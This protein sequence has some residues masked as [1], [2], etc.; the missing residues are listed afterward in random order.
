VGEVIATTFV[1][2]AGAWGATIEPRLVYGLDRSN[3][4][5]ML[6]VQFGHAMDGLCWCLGEFEALSATLAT[7]YPVAT[8]T[9]TGEAVDKTIDDQIAVSGR[10]QGGTVASV[11]YRCGTSP[12]ANLLWEI[13]GSHGDLVVTSASGRLQYAD[14]RIQGR[15]ADGG[16]EDLPVPDRYRLVPNGSPAQMHD[17]LAHAYALMRSDLKLGTNHVPTF[18]DA[19]LRH[20]MLDAIERAAWT[21]TRQTYAEGADTPT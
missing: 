1:G 14:L 13:N 10:L 11:H 4:V 9:D 16:L 21:G 7:R 12:V 3:G 19:V 15:K 2:S 17:T 5:S 18:E 6:T 8:R 20:R